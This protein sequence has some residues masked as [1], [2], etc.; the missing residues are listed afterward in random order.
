MAFLRFHARHLFSALAVALMCTFTRANEAPGNVAPVKIMA[1]GDSITAGADFFSS[2]RYSLWEKLFAAGYLVEFVGTQTSET[3]VGPLAHEGYG[4]KNTEYLAANVPA[5][6]REHPADVVLLHSGHN[7]FAEERPVHGIVAATEKL[8][9]EFRAVNPRVMVLLAQVIP[10]GKLPKYSYI[11]DLNREIALLA[12]RLDSP[13]QR[14]ML[15]D[16]ARGF[17]WA[18]DTVSDLVHPNARGAEKMAQVWFGALKK[19]LPPT[20]RVFSPKRIAYKIASGGTSLELHVFSPEKSAETAATNGGRPA[21]LFFFGG[22]WTHGTPVQFYPECAHFAERGFVAISADYRV[23]STHGTTSFESAEDARDAFGWVRA[24]ASEL[25]IDPA[26][27]VLAGASAGGHLAAVTALKSQPGDEPAALLLFYPV[28]D[29][30]PTGFGHALFGER[31]A[32]FSPLHLLSDAQRVPAPSL[33]LAG[34]ADVAV[35]EK[36]VRAFQ[37]GVQA[38]GGRCDVIIYPGGGHPLYAYRTG[39]EPRRS[40]VLSAADRFFK[41]LWAA[42]DPVH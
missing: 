39:G 38:K 16:Q 31:F 3:R 15:V 30:G 33:I 10:A 26:R 8:I 4:G 29:T 9:G 36:T 6:F 25:G 40:E 5:H 23:K 32:E 21:I 42:G 27:I 14:V 37:S 2:Y 34:D 41:T 22:G 18:V 1:V 28:L 24:H 12:A 17:D 13:S 20:T 7:H 11:P 19:V 35:P